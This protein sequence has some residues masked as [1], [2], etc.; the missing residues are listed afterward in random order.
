[1]NYDEPTKNAPASE[2]SQT[3]AAMM[4]EWPY[5]APTHIV[6]IPEFRGNHTHG[7]TYSEAVKQGEELIDPLIMWAEHDGMLLPQPR[8]FALP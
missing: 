5:E 1:M 7:E 8:V 3:H 6:S 4:I 2:A